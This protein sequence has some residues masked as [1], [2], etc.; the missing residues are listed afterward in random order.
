MERLKTAAILVLLAMLAGSIAWAATN[1]EAEVRITARQLD[2]GRVEFAL[3][4]RVDGEWGERQL[5]RS[6]FFPADATVGRWLNSSSLTIQ[7]TPAERVAVTLPQA[8]TTGHWYSTD[9]GGPLGGGR[10]ISMG[11]WEHAPTNSGWSLSL[12]CNSGVASVHLYRPGSNDWSQAGSQQFRY[13]LDGE[14]TVSA[15]WSHSATYGYRRAYRPPDQWAQEL[16]GRD[17][18][19]LQYGTG[20]I[21]DLHGLIEFDLRGMQ[22]VDVWP[23]IRDCF[24]W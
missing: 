5:P 18:L 20:L 21:A 17:T 24:G 16:V 22:N 15:H 1:G 3:Q 4:Q 9:R 7:A 14:S 11:L 19:Q 2:D 23:T 13:R 10:D 6:R 8:G 12:Q